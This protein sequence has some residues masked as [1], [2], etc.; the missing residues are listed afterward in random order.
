VVE[1][2]V[3]SRCRERNFDFEKADGIFVPPL[4]FPKEPV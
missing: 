1:A 4:T 2:I 3:L